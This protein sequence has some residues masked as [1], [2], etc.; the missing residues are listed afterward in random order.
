MDTIHWLA[1]AINIYPQTRG[2][3]CNKHFFM[4]FSLPAIPTRYIFIRYFLQYRLS[5]CSRKQCSSW[6]A[7]ESTHPTRC[8]DG[9]PWQVLSRPIRWRVQLFFSAHRNNT[10]RCSQSHCSVWWKAE[11]EKDKGARRR[12]LGHSPIEKEEKKRNKAGSKEE[13]KE[14]QVFHSV[15]KFIFENL[16]LN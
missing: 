6:D 7:R 14:K 12:G 13:E 5:Y 1:V 11:A 2:S 8:P 15:F 3:F 9:S 4:G 16:I 10:S